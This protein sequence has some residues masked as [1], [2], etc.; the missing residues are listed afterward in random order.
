M[1]SNML[2]HNCK[3]QQLHIKECV[4]FPN[5]LMWNQNKVQTQPNL[6]LVFL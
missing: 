4:R 1:F 2:E 5:L 6:V 3:S